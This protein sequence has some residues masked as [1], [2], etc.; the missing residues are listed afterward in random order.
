MSERV[1]PGQQPTNAL[2]C[3]NAACGATYTS[4]VQQCLMCGSLLRGTTLGVR[5][6]IEALLGRGGMG[7]V[8]RATDLT[9]NRAVA[10]K[11]LSPSGG[12][13]G[14]NASELRMRFFREARLAAQLDHP[15]IVPVLHFDSDG[16]LAYLVM[17]L[18]TGGTL[19]QRTRKHE[20]TDP[21]LVSN[22]L[23]QIAAALDFAHQRPQPII[24][25]D[26]KPGNFLFHEDGRLCLADF[27]VARILAG[28]SSETAQLTR[29][30]VVLGSLS[31]MAPEQV[32]GQA[33]PAS[34]QYSTGVMLYELL[35]GALP[36]EGGDNYSLIVQHASVT[37]EPPSTLVS[38]FPSGLDAVILR[39]LAKRPEDRFPT[40]S[41]LS[42]AFRDA[43]ASA[44]T[45]YLTPKE[46]ASA[47]VALPTTARIH[48]PQ[49]DDPRGEMYT[50]AATFHPPGYDRYAAWQRPSQSLHP[51]QPPITPPP[52]PRR[53]TPLR[54]VAF[55]GLALLLCF[56]ALA[57]V[58][59][60]RNNRNTT[61]AGASA[62]ATQLA[63]TSTPAEAA[64][65]LAILQAAEG[66]EPIYQDS[67]L[68]TGHKAGWVLTAPA[69]FESDGLHLPLPTHGD[70]KQTSS[71]PTTTAQQKAL[72]NPSLI[73]VNVTF[74]GASIYYGFAFFSLTLPAHALFLNT[75]GG[76]AV[77]YL[78]EKN[79]VQFG[80]TTTNPALRLTPGTTYQLE[81]LL[82]E[83]QF[84]IFLNKQ[85]VATV[86]FSPPFSH[87]ISF[88]LFSI[89]TSGQ[90]AGEVAYS[91]LTIYPI[92]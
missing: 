40:M 9:L 52:N 79:N 64:Q 61:Q 70:N 87:A 74:T 65:E 27:G 67:L 20:P 69:R 71:N 29:A 82:Q 2:Q 84:V 51:G 83:N 91:H 6:Q 24:H 22:W 23:R 26:V 25:R 18:L 7:A 10:I 62:T 63:A 85:W 16:P 31:Y 19:S 32:N 5:F 57:G 41:A 42:V 92:A 55:G 13:V 53:I 59:A 21:T 15:N 47:P 72:I 49:D 45:A 4:V 56:L 50:E 48:A 30:G 86:P 46:K 88:A 14:G 1:L 66:H 35:T 75:T 43:L 90:P 80:E 73:E 39:T 28:E 34:D 17:P 77:A 37:P 8:Y 58:S 38:G 76:Y 81:V 12:F 68:R 33:A 3:S 89:G 78:Y 36:F 44:P 60:L 54:V 11:V